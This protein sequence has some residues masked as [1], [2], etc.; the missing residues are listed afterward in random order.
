MQIHYVFHSREWNF[1]FF[2]LLHEYGI[3]VKLDKTCY[4]T[5]QK[6]TD[7]L[8]IEI[9]VLFIGACIMLSKLHNVNIHKVDT[10]FNHPFVAHVK[11]EN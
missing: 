10:S 6:I 8:L 4:K 1:K 9:S 3:S 5:L 2:R 11:L 7:R